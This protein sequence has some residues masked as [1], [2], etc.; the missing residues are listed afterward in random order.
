[1][2]NVDLIGDELRFQGYRVALLVESGIPAST[3]EA[4]VDNL[5][6]G[7]LNQDERPDPCNCAHMQGCPNYKAEDASNTDNATYEEVMRDLTHNL[8]PFTR[9]GLLKLQDVERVVKQIIE[10]KGQE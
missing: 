2:L 5:R 3:M 10:E 4:F 8:K 1:M 9:G 6:N 7:L